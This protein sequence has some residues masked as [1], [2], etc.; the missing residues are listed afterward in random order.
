MVSWQYSKNKNIIGSAAVVGIQLCHVKLM[1]VHMANSFEFLTYYETMRN[2][3][4]NAKRLFL[5]T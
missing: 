5:E 2:R 4:M 3:F 1:H